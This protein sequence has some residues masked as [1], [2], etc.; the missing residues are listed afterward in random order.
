MDEPSG[1]V[2][3]DAQEAVS[4]RCLQRQAGP[5]LDSEIESIVSRIEGRA[6]RRLHPSYSSSSKAA[7]RLL[8]LMRAYGGTVD[9]PIHVRDTWR[10][11]CE[12]E[13]GRFL[14]IGANE[15]LAICSAFAR[16]HRSGWRLPRSVE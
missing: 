15:A 1:C 8:P 5:E 12:N 11:R 6:P 4:A 7:R 9:E 3:E 14:M 10:C 2:L 16:I 13:D